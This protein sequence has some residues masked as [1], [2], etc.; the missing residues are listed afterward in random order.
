MLVQA[1]AHRIDIV[2]A[3]YP[4]RPNALAGSAAVNAFAS[5]AA[6]LA[7]TFPQVRRYVI[8]NEFN[9]PRFFQPQFLADCRPASGATYMELLAKTYD[10]VKA[11]DPGVRIV[12]SVSPHGNDNCNAP[13]NISRS[14]YRFI[15]DMGVTYRSMGRDRPA[16]DEF[17]LH[18]YPNEST[19]PL[20]KGFAWPNMNYA[21]LGRLKQALWDAFGG[22]PQP[23]FGNAAHRFGPEP[24]RRS[25]RRAS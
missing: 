3:L 23:T 16:W 1:R 18:A 2:F 6:G 12:T 14:P 7:R 20:T 24:R 5:W 11:V 8:G 17:G 13:S 9:Q 21:N 10:A 4:K 15:Y 22:S 19:D 25:C